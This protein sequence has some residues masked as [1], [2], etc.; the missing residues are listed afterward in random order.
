MN[1]VSDDLV[2]RLRNRA[3]WET[4]ESEFD[5]NLHIDWIAADEIERLQSIIIKAYQRLGF[6]SRKNQTMQILGAGL[7]NAQDSVQTQL[8]SGAD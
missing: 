2:A 5:S 1:I 3:N 7:P 4:R 8:D 6:T